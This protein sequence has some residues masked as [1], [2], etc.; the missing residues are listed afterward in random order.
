MISYLGA[1]ISFSPEHFLFITHG[2]LRSLAAAAFNNLPRCPLTVSNLTPIPGFVTCFDSWYGS[3][4]HM[5]E[6]FVEEWIL[7]EAAEVHGVHVFPKHASDA[8]N[9]PQH[10]LTA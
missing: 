9:L 1:S 6:T 2:S 5:R 10:L 8:T 4:S 3:L 7:P